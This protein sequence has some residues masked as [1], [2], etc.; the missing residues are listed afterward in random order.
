MLHICKTIDGKPKNC[1]NSI[2]TPP[3]RLNT[4]H[5]RYEEARQQ[6][7]QYCPFYFEHEDGWF[8]YK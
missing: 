5:P 2:D 6:M 7:L 4:T 3:E 8:K 1:D